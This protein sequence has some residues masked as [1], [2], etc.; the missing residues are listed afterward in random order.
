MRKHSRRIALA[1]LFVFTMAM[2][3]SPFQAVAHD[4]HNIQL[5]VTTDESSITADAEVISGGTT[6][7]ALDGKWRF[8]LISH[9]TNDK[10][11]DPGKYDVDY[12]DETVSQS[13]T[14]ET[15]ELEPGD[16]QVVARFMGK[17][18]H[19]E[20]EKVDHELRAEFDVTI[21]PADDGGNGGDQDGDSGATGGDDDGSTGGDGTGGDQSDGGEVPRNVNI[22]V[23]V[24]SIDT[25]AGI[26]ESHVDAEL[27]LAQS[28]SADGSGIKGDWT[29]KATKKSDDSLVDEKTLPDQEGPK[30]DTALDVTEPG[31]Y[32]IQVT[33]DGTVDG[34][35][36]HG[37]GNKDYEIT[38]PGEPTD[39]PTPGDEKL[40]TGYSYKDGKHILQT[41][42]LN[43]EMA[44]GNW[45]IAIAHETA[46]S[47][48][49]ILY[50]YVEDH[51]GVIA[52]WEFDKLKPGHYYGV[53]VFEGEADGE[54]T[55]LYEEFE[56]VVEEDGTITPDPDNGDKDN[57]GK[58]DPDE[59]K[60]AIEDIKGGKMPDTAAEQPTYML[61][62]GIVT[63]LGLLIL[64]I[65]YRRKLFSVF[66]N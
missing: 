15:L 49:D 41:T 18:K 42:M 65:V 10:A 48:D 32:L 7:T 47:E 14:F 46:Q 59:G 39:P 58:M 55:A 28:Q 29:F 57:G 1:W 27:K 6:P 36:V 35:E 20:D 25:E 66:G 56:F 26:L 13:H 17:I 2:V 60:K 9:E 12:T 34:E 23:T 4:K 5:E 64:G 44:K 31:E 30:A 62:G 38:E 45:G 63:A 40:K 22:D 24:T 52:E 21:P 3:I 8:N 11:T 53:S 51:E 16:Y 37:E 33:F 50:K 43:A 61:Y 19:G 54:I